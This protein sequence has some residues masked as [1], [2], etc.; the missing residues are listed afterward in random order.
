MFAR[1]LKQ[2]FWDCYDHLGTLF[3]W[4]I[5][6][7]TLTF[8]SSVLLLHLATPLATELPPFA[9]VLF[10]FILLVLTA[11]LVI[12]IWFAPST[13]YGKLVAA[14]KYPG[15]RV[16]MRGLRAEF[17]RVWRYGFLCATIAGILLVNIWFYVAS[18]EFV[19]E[20][21]IVG[22]LLAGLCF[23]L[24]LLLV[25]SMGIGLPLLVREGLTARRA[26]RGAA[27]E[28]LRSPGL[29]LGMFVFLVSLWI[30]AAW[31]RFAPIFLFGFSGTAMFLNSLYDVMHPGDEAG[32]GG[33]V[34]STAGDAATWRQVRANEKVSE[35]ARMARARYERTFRD[36]LRPWEG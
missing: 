14:E 24:L 28:V 30:I 23:W 11:P 22:H 15:F 7:F 29:V 33:E 6:L 13:H 10:L 20:Q 31:L 26:F 16:L 12:A 18:G 4:N 9:R 1:V 3:V 35:Q 2:W 32:D 21:P 25:A 5:L 8:S 17:L 27:V 34:E 36:L 19:P